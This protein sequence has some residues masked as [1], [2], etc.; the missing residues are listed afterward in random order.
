MRKESNDV[1]F[2]TS[3][4][5]NF[6]KCSFLSGLDL[7]SLHD[8][9]LAVNKSSPSQYIKLIQENGRKH[10][11]TYL[12]LLTGIY[13]NFVDLRGNYTS[14]Q[15]SKLTLQAMNDGAQLIYQGGLIDDIWEARPDFL[16]RN[17]DTS[18]FGNYS[19]EV[20]DTKLAL[21]VRAGAVL[22]VIHY[23]EMLT[24]YLGKLPT[25]A[26]L[27][28][29]NNEKRNFKVKDYL[30]Y[31]RNLR[32]RFF[33]FIKSSSFTNSE[34]F[35]CQHCEICHWRDYCNDIWKSKDHLCQVAFIKKI[36]IDKLRA[37][38]INTM[39]QLSEVPSNKNITSLNSATFFRLQ[40]QA[41][42]QVR[43]KKAGK[44]LFELIK[45]DEIAWR[46]G[47]NMNS[48]RRGFDILPRAAEGD[49]FFDME[50]DPLS[51]DKLE[52]LFGL[53]YLSGQEEIY[54]PF[55][56]LSQEEEKNTF[57]NFLEFLT[58]HLKSFPSAHVYHYAPYEKIALRRL[59]NKYDL[60]QQ[61]ID[62]FLREGKL[63]D[64][65]Q[66]VRESIRISESKYSIK[67]L[68]KFYKKEFGQ[69]DGAV[70]NA[71]DSLIF[72]EEWKNSGEGRNSEILRE[73]ENYNLEDV[74]S[75]YFLRQWLLSIM[76]NNNINFFSASS[77]ESNH[78]D[79]SDRAKNYAR[80]LAII[81]RKLEAEISL[82]SQP[83][84]EDKVIQYKRVLID[85]LDFH[86][87][88]QKP[89]WWSYFD[90]LEAGFQERAEREDCIV[91]VDEVIAGNRENV[92]RSLK[93]RCKYP[94]QNFSIKTGDRCIDLASRSGLSDVLIERDKNIISFKKGVGKDLPRFPIDIGLDGPAENIDTLVQ[95]IFRYAA[96]NER[97]S[98]ITAVLKRDEPRILCNNEVK[99][100]LGNSN[101]LE[102]VTDII[103]GLNSSYLFVQGPPGTG[104]TFLGSKVVVKL[105]QEGK[106]VGVTSNSHKAIINFLQKIETHSLEDNFFFLG[107]KKSNLADKSQRYSNL[108]DSNS[109][110]VDCA[111]N[112]EM[113]NGNFQL[114][115]GT[116]W[117]FSQPELDSLLDYLVVEEA[118][119]MSLAT[120]IAAGTSS[121]SLILIGDQN[122]LEQPTQGVHPNDSG[123][124][125]INYLLQTK[126]N[127]EGVL[128]VVPPTMGIFLDKT[129][130]LHPYIC[131]FISEAFYQSKLLPNSKNANRV[132]LLSDTL[133][134]QL[135][136][137]GIKYIPIVH[138]G[139]KKHSK[140]EVDKI[141]ELYIRLLGQ[142]V[143]ENKQRKK[144]ITFEDI[145]VVAPFNLQVQELRKCL[146]EGARVGTIDKFQG[147]EAEVVLISM[148]TSNA[149]SMPREVEF[150]FSKNRLNVAITRAKCLSVIVASQEL[151]TFPCKTPEQLTLVNTLC[152]LQE[153]YT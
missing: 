16:V 14:E 42:L 17:N 122:Q 70:I 131:E 140:S 147:Q 111:K 135:I 41:E 58:S 5:I 148:T 84:L 108:K 100:V 98:A 10:E 50:S 89:Q 1:F 142:S 46:R 133:S 112:K 130:R 35:P 25:H 67:N 45:P 104:K 8:E 43:A 129:Y 49:L 91:S 134:N 73:I 77:N 126:N 78:A 30:F 145:L 75:T 69:R 88:D 9:A 23:S 101:S 19:Y 116:A 136:P 22:Q 39:Q 7:R 146:P 52:Y 141:R 87:R 76:E 103:K 105:L 44:A 13:P 107:A 94:P 51:T 60:G 68:E 47:S 119:Q 66:V 21:T 85:L 83:L 93:F 12:E 110:I 118:G 81:K 36:Q 32:K 123:I 138:S 57:R 64:L 6:S 62:Q 24:E 55:W 102:S 153:V 34:P 92:G 114:M 65:Y 96:N 143:I 79:I 27:I 11:L 90:R 132:L 63:I 97:Y 53:F 4:I 20:W 31:F 33:T 95:S 144:V 151:L 18:I 128:S 125:A 26:Y 149:E 15:R 150:L 106:R 127:D 54:K 72:F 117:F 124:S 40:H 48:E 120:L 121:K 99:K 37:A 115:A 74:R 71:A 80:D 28:L 113:L 86:K 38:E 29:G 56:A 152:W 82:E 3:D 139:C 61:I 109:M 137:C 2:S 59:S